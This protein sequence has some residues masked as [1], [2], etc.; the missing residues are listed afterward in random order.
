[1]N[2]PGPLNPLTHKYD[3]DFVPRFRKG[4]ERLA[5]D[6]QKYLKHLITPEAAFLFA[7]AFGPE[8]GLMLWPFIAE[9]SPADLM[10][11]EAN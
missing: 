9:D 4:I 6:E 2:T 1:M 10:A 3:T 7:K 11:G 5:P 8:M